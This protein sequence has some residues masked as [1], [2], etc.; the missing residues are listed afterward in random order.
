MFKELLFSRI[1]NP[2]NMTFEGEDRD[3]EIYYLF[4]KSVITNLPWVFIALFLIITP[5]IANS[6]VLFVN[7]Q[8]LEA[9]PAGRL[10]V[11]SFFWY[12]F[13][14]GYIFQSFLHWYFNV[15]I[16]TNKRIFDLDFVGLIYVNVSEAH[17]ETIQ[18]VTSTVNGSLR[19]IF[20]I[21]T[22]T[23]QTAAEQRE[24]EFLDVS[25]PAKVR[26]IISDIVTEI[27][28]RDS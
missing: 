4:R 12:L 21:G 24:F 18:D 16:I 14:I 27:R 7:P 8:A 9:I 26:D 20:N 22:V 13:T 17:L 3:E 2:A 15:Y 19:V 10:T 6:I 28:E 23:I 1:K 5:L 11:F 25:Q